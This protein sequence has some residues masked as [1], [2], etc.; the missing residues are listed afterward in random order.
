MEMRVDHTR[1]HHPA[2]A[3]EQIVD[4]ARALVVTIVDRLHPAA[5]VD[6]QRGKAV[7]IAVLVDPHTGDVLD[8]LVGGS[9]GGDKRCGTGKE[10]SADHT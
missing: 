3:V 10:G 1:K 5:I 4:I 7:D 2:F 9:R 8:Q 6:Q